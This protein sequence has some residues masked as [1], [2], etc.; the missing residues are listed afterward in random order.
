MNGRKSNCQ[1]R[2]KLCSNF[3]VV[4]FPFWF[5]FTFAFAFALALALAF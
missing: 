4:A 3:L 5:G 2:N 1:Y